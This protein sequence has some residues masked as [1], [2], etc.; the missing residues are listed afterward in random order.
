MS[1][2]RTSG[3][4][5]ETHEASQMAVGASPGGLSGT[6]EH[7]IGMYLGMYLGTEEI[8]VLRSIFWLDAPSGGT[9]GSK[10]GLDAEGAW[11]ED[12]CIFRGA[13]TACQAGVPAVVGYS[14]SCTPR[15]SRIGRTW[16]GSGRGWLGRLRQ[17]EEMLLELSDHWAREWSRGLF[18]GARDL[19]PSPSTRLHPRRSHPRGLARGRKGPGRQTRF[20]LPNCLLPLWLWP[21]GPGQ[22]VESRRPNGCKQFGRTNR[23]CLPGPS[24]P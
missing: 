12:W 4:G 18:L 22:V 21:W 1:H 8:W 15:L 23:V 16:G 19:D 14:E 20:V 24:R 13:L 2:S 17:L 9:L 11:N 7:G 3:V 6:G 5:S 10:I